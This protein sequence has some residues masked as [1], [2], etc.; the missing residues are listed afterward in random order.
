MRVLA[1]YGSFHRRRQYCC[2][3]IVFWAGTMIHAPSYYAG[4]ATAAQLSIDRP[5]SALL[6]GACLKGG[7]SPNQCGAR[8]AHMA[9]ASVRVCARRVAIAILAARPRPPGSAC[10]EQRRLACVPRSHAALFASD[11][12]KI[13]YQPLH[14]EISNE[15]A[16][17]RSWRAHARA[18]CAHARQRCARPRSLRSRRALRARLL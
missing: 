18:L 3:Q 4:A 12:D 5:L 7:A 15:Y 8:Q 11:D 14:H 6:H 16:L 9:R 1:W 17:A 10:L 13:L 2:S